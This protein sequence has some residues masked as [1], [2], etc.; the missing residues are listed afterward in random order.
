MPDEKAIRERVVSEL[1]DATDSP[2]DAAAIDDDT[3]LRDDLGL[4]SLQ[5][6]TMVLSLEEA[7]D[8]EVGD[9]EIEALATVGDVLALI[10]R[11]T[12]E[13]AG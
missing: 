13:Q 10:R 9:E 12:A 11:K 5:A 7:F 1:I 3:H 8:V 2:L 6:V 4:D